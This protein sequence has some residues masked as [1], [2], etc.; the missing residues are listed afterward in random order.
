MN[1]FTYDPVASCD[2]MLEDHVLEV[3]WKEKGR[4]NC[5]NETS[6]SYIKQP[7]SN[8]KIPNLQRFNQIKSTK[9]L[10][11]AVKPYKEAT[12]K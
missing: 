11:K 3:D 2:R 12:E 8:I 7:K 10:G 9:R 1:A 5:N 4:T 6:T